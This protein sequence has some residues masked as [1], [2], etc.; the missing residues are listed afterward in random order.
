MHIGRQ[1]KIIRPVFYMYVVLPRCVATVQ[2]A[3]YAQS[4]VSSSLYQLT[5]LCT[6]AP[7][8]ACALIGGR[9]M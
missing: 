1:S 2:L 7:H 3:Q 8:N 5:E 9:I 4:Y 6:K